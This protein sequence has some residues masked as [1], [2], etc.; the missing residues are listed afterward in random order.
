[1]SMPL[2]PGVQLDSI[3]MAEQR[4]V[5]IMRCVSVVVVGGL[6]DTKLLFIYLRLVAPSHPPNNNKITQ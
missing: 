4:G 2:R 1:M 5:S 3:G 6:I